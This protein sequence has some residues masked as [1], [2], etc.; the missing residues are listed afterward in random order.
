MAPP[1]RHRGQY[2]AALTTYSSLPAHYAPHTW[3]ALES[4]M[5][6]RALDT[7]TEMK[8]PRDNEWMHNLLSYLKSFIEHQGSEL[9]IHEDDKIEYVSRLVSSLTDAANDLESGGSI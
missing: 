7:H 4:Y 2:T 1:Y 6:S 3:T 8:Q 9:L 5:L